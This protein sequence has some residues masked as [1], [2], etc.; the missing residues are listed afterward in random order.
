MVQTLK[1]SN[2]GGDLRWTL[3]LSIATHMHAQV[4]SR[5]DLGA[6][7]APRDELVAIHIHK[8]KDQSGTRCLP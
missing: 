3:H 8:E 2:A 4:T 5:T 6:G 1:W 7:R